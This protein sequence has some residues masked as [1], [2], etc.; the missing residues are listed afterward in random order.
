M[1]RAL[2]Y[3]PDGELH[4]IFEYGRRKKK[5]K[6]MGFRPPEDV[7]GKVYRH[8]N[9]RSSIELPEDEDEEEREGDEEDAEDYRPR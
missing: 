4:T 2:L 5:R 8:R 9:E 6:K 1:R 7:R 3:G